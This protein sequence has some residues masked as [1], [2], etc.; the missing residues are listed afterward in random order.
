MLGIGDELDWS[1]TDDA[2]VIKTP[3]EKPCK[4]AYVFKINRRNKL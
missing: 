3:P 1:F 4:Y 2:L